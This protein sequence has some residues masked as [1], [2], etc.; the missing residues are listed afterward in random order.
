M[1][2]REP[3]EIDYGRKWHVMAV[4]GVGILLGTIDSS[5]VNVALPSL[6]EHFD[7]RFAVVQWVV[8]GYLLTLAVLMLSVGRLADIVGKRS[9]YLTG[10]LVFTGGSLMC[11]LSPT[12]H[13]L[14]GF[15]VVQAVGASMM[16]ALGMGIL[17][18][19]FPPG[20]RGKALGTAGGIVSIGIMAGPALGGV[21]I[22]AL[23]WHWIFFVNVPL[24]AVSSIMV[25]RLLPNIIR[26]R[27][28]RFDYR[29][30]LAMCG[31]LLAFLLALTL[32][33]QPGFGDRRILGLFGVSVILLVTFVLTE[34]RSEYPM[35][36][37]RLFRN[38]SFAFRL[39]TGFVCFVAMG[40]VV[41]LMPFYLENVLR[42]D[43]H[44]VGL[45]LAVVPVTAGLT[46][47]VS[48]SL[49]DRFG[50]VLISI[51]GLTVVLAGF[52]NLL[53]LSEQTTS[54]GY[55]LRFLPIVIGLGMFQ[56]PNNSG[57]MGSA[58]PDKLGVVSSL[59]SLTRT[60]GQSTG[61]AVLGALW[62]RRVALYSH[63]EFEMGATRTTPAY[64]VRGL[65]DTFWLALLLILLGLVCAVSGWLWERQNSGR[66]SQSAGF[67]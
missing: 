9:V 52:A 46:S 65:H 58:P 51:L 28:Q 66:A 10:M 62:V 25:P 14:I 19:A 39:L 55:V 36:D 49:S 35:V 1:S 57:I 38:L 22:D 64:Q 3:T 42:Y 47:P 53:S 50:T 11:G 30:A 56:S 20:E 37:L 34:M 23:S 33:Q 26:S 18:E 17:A 43:P 16:V 44:Q 40:G 63:H 5:I 21:L 59:L 4:V 31:G 41:L 60:L 7:T 27:G 67:P 54:L 8:L 29:G 13:W 15:R 12:I 48:G 45:L 32:G 61:I 6:V 2:M 24:G